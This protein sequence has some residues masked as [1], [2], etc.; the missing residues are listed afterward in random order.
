MSYFRPFTSSAENQSEDAIHVAS[1]VP[2]NP[3]ESS[4]LNAGYFL[5]NG[6]NI[7]VSIIF[8]VAYS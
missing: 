5:H 1:T 3:L 7:T 2:Y 4:W 6:Y 8:S